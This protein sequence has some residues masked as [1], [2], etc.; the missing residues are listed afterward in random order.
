MKPMEE[1][2]RF[3]QTLDDL[4]IG[5]LI[6]NSTEKEK[7]DI[8]KWLSEN[9]DNRHY[10]DQIRDIY[11]LGKTTKDPSGFDKEKSLAK[12]KADYYK[13]KYLESRADKE[14]KRP[15]QIRFMKAMSFAAS[16]LLIVSLGFNLQHILQPAGNRMS[17][18]ET[19][20]NEIS[21]P[22][23]SRTIITLP[24][25][26]LVWL[27]AGSKIRFPMDFLNGD[28]KVSLVGEGY[29]E[30]VKYPEKRFIVHTSDLAIK[31]WGTKFNVKAYP[32]ERI[33]QT[34]L[35][36]GSISIKK[37]KGGPFEKE[38]YLMPNQTAVY[39][40]SVDGASTN[41]LAVH[42]PLGKVKPRSILVRN[43]INTVLFTSWKDKKWIIDGQPL[44]DLAHEL[45]RRFNVEIRFENESIKQYRFTGILSDETFEQVLEVIKFSA[46]IEYSVANNLVVLREN[47]DSKSNYDKFLKR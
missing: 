47:V 2:Q 20:F 33:I 14:R 23:G 46:P 35:V 38:T 45:E 41:K 12:I 11:Y 4:L 16:V 36:E 42:P 34:T 31:V 28:R 9:N 27:N 5:Y 7:Q 1:N 39:Y 37:L 40:K 19:A 8:E 25:G 22:K 3:R 24:D 13:L 44:G 18:G 26:T 30:V 15:S 21:A 32:E 6:G 10:L 17:M 43:Q 29:F